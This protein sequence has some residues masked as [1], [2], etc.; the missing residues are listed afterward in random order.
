MKFWRG[1]SREFVT[2]FSDIISSYDVFTVTTPHKPVV[3]AKLST[4][5]LSSGDWF[6]EGKKTVDLD[7][8]VVTWDETQ[9][10]T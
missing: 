9:G 7:G 8:V 6:S 3:F 4:L 1:D 10:T 2:K 5:D